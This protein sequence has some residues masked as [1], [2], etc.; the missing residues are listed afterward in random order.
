MV[1]GGDKNNTKF[2][3]FEES[4]DLMAEPRRILL[5]LI[6]RAINHSTMERNAQFNR[7]DFCHPANSP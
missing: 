1:V 4:D 6:L 7:F 3:V 2:S 5:T